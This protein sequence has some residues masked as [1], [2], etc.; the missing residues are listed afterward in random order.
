MVDRIKKIFLKE[1]LP[2]TNKRDLNWQ[3]IKKATAVSLLSLV[4]V[5]LIMPAPDESNATFVEERHQT[6]VE[7]ENEVEKINNETLEV[8]S[9]GS[10]YRK[11]PSN[12]NHLYGSS[13]SAS[14]SD[15]NTG[16]MII[17]RNDLQSGNTLPMSSTIP[18]IL[19]ASIKVEGQQIPVMALVTQDVY[20]KENLAIPKGSSLFG[21]ASTSTGNRVSIEWIQVQFAD[22]S[23]KKI[24]ATSMGADGRIGVAGELNGNAATNTLGLGLTKLIGAYAE[25]SQETGPFGAN[26]GGH[27][28]G[29]RNAVAET[30]RD[31]SE[32]WARQLQE[33]VRWVT[34]R[35][36]TALN[37]LVTQ[38]FV[39]R[40]PG[41][42]YGQ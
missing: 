33:Q 36:G 4:V 13:S 40:D 35:E 19:P 6:Y 42:S 20:Y 27:E 31:R 30:A 18:L 32:D 5:L 41:A 28:N 2:F 3:V 9:G 14:S 15:K 17:A 39:F 26:R 38:P 37:A 10:K 1:P 34:I 24:Q 12:L 7:K 16:S 11:A 22:G 25:G 23:E 29:L 8:L 21:H